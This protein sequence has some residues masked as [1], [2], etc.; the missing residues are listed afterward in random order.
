MAYDKD[1]DAWEPPETYWLISTL[2]NCVFLVD[3][4]T[5]ARVMAS[6]RD[7][8]SPETW[9]HFTDLLGG[10]C[11]TSLGNIGSMWQETTYTRGRASRHELHKKADR[12]QAQDEWD[13]ERKKRDLLND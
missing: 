2:D 10:E 11:G 5:A 4:F 7:G 9:V 13:A 12:Q 1:D 6:K 3:D 8:D